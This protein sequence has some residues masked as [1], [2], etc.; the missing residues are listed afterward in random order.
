M[1][2][3][4]KL[5]KEFSQWERILS[6]ASV[7]CGLARWER[8]LRA[9]E[10]ELAD[11]NAGEREALKSLRDFALP[12][13]ESVASLP[14]KA[15]WE[16]WLDSLGELAMRTI[17]QPGAVHAILDELQ[18]MRGAGVVSLADVLATLEP[19]LSSRRVEEDTTRYGAVFVGSL[20]ESSGM[21]FP[22]VFV[23]GLN[24]GVLPKP[25]REDPLLLDS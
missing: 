5:T 21:R 2:S 14:G 8:R 24:E 9:Y 22:A 1:K 18:A 19:E 13:I 17:D 7:I 4:R 15:D 12:I 20:S 16:T 3:R 25:V 11:D 10:N 6:K 23:P